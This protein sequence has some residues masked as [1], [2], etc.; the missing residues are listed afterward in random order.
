MYSLSWKSIDSG[1]T[2]SSTAS[3]TN[4]PSPPNFDRCNVKNE[5]KADSISS[6]KDEG[7]E[8]DE[9]IDFMLEDRNVDRKKVGYFFYFV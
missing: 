2:F 6:N 8:M 1:F 3:R 9:N 5:R 7:I 4:T